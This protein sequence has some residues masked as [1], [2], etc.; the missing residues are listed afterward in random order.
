MAERIHVAVQ[1]KIQ[2]TFELTALPCEFQR[3]YAQLLVSRC[4]GIYRTKIRK[5]CRTAEFPATRAYSTQFSRFL[6]VA[7]LFHVYFSTKNSRI[8]LYQLS[9]IYPA[10]CRVVKS[11]FRAVSLVFY[12]RNFHFKI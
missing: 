4:I 6:S 5:P 7:Y 3:V 10:F 2:T 12:I 8:F 1:F 11:N 9:E